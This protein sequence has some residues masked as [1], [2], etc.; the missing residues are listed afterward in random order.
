MKT[1]W[2]SN[3]QNACLLLSGNVVLL[4]IQK[5]R[6]KRGRKSALLA[7]RHKSVQG[8]YQTM[9]LFVCLPGHFSFFLFNRFECGLL[10]S[11][12]LSKASS[13]PELLAQTELASRSLFLD[14]RRSVL[15]HQWQSGRKS[16]GLSKA[17]EEAQARL[18]FGI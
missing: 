8:L 1:Y 12:L 11:R 14:D 4:Q 13:N 3:Q 7:T 6:W 10:I 18:Q 9:Y 16:H 17:P 5:L 15:L 2:H